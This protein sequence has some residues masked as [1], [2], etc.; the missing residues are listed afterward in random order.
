MSPELYACPARSSRWASPDVQ[1]MLPWSK[2]PIQLPAPVKTALKAHKAGQN[3]EWAKAGDKW[4]ALDLMFPT[5]RG[6]PFDH[7][8]Y[9]RTVRRLIADADIPGDWTAHEMRHS[10]ISILADQGTPV[11]DIANLVG[12]RDRRT[13]E[14]IY[15][16]RLD[17]P[18]A[19]AA[20]AMD[21]IFA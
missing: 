15:R 21:E 1:A 13:I 14:R 7:A 16:H 9:R 5:S 10:A 12:H 8:N 18:V 3:K 17:T 6:T 20:E 11:D 4:V 2:R 19:V